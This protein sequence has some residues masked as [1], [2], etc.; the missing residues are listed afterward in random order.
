MPDGSVVVA[1]VEL[2]GSVVVA[3]V[4]PDGSVVVAVVELDEL[5]EPLVAA[6]SLEVGLVGVALV[7]LCLLIESTAGKSVAA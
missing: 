5:V 6:V 4:E 3:V 7:V 2:D 1:V